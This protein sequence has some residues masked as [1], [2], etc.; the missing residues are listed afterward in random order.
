MTQEETVTIHK[1]VYESLIDDSYMLQCLI[2]LLV[3]L[4]KIQ[5]DSI[6]CLESAGVDNWSGYEYAMEEYQAGMEEE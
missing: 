3:N 2:G 1:K 4:K 6:Q 5:N